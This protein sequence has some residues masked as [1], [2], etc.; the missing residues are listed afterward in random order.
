MMK[1]LMIL[2]LLIIPVMTIAQRFK[3]GIVAG[4]NAS[5]IEGDYTGGYNKAGIVAGAFVTT[6]FRSNW[7]GLMEIRY[8][9]KGSSI[10]LDDD[11]R[12]KIRLQY[13]EMPV[14]ATYDIANKFQGQAGVSIGYLFR[15]SQNEGTGYED[16]DRYD[17][18]EV[19]ASLG[20]NYRV[21]DKLSMNI[22]LSFSIIPIYQQYP[23]AM[24]LDYASFNNVLSF[25][26][27][28]RIGR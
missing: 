15:E 12:R 7:G 21:F 18:F 6:E 27:Y 2:I 26:A 13:I 23:G 11:V 1:R 25:T 28:Y 14:L 5:Q 20:M 8:A 19:A 24:D 16:F 3:G 10:P 9:E 22:R 17:D 4:L